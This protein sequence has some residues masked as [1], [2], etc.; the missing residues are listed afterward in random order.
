MFD[1]VII[2]AGISGLACAHYLKTTSTLNTLVLE[3]N[4]TIGGRIQTCYD[5]NTPIELGAEFIHGDFAS[6]HKLVRQAN[7]KIVP[8]PRI[9]NLWWSNG[10]S[11]AQP[12]V[13][14]STPQAIKIARLL[15][16]YKSLLERKQT[17]EKDQSLKDYL[18]LN[19]KE[20]EQIADVLF[21]QTCCTTLDKLSVNDIIL[22][23]NVSTAGD[24][25]SRIAEGYGALLKWISKDL[26]IKLNTKVKSIDWN[27][28][29]VKI[30]TDEKKIECKQCVITV[31]VS[32]LQKGEILF[33]PPLPKWKK[34]AIWAF[35]FELGTKLIYQFRKYYWDTKLS[36]MA[37]PGICCRW[38]TPDYSRSTSS[39]TIISY[40]TSERAKVI[41]QLTEQ[42]ALDLGLKEL[43]LLLG[44]TF[45]DLK[46]DLV[47]SMRVSWAKNTFVLGAYASLKIG[48]AENTRKQLAAPIGSLLF[49]AGEATAYHSNP[50]TVN[51]ALDTGVRAAKEILITQ[52]TNNTA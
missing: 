9:G 12:V 45:Q 31:P 17:F 52:K 48:S 44:Y 6:T 3:A 7:L 50:Q 29:H 30:Q 26:N 16:Q 21:A 49:F 15:K 46:K 51:G 43:S 41:D 47:K 27:G 11:K 33:S 24:G 32:I 13:D 40:I 14:Q 35:Q 4:S 8:V 20:E 18:Q 38:W 1:V 25:E 23:N 22:E 39:P 34:D 42:E 5:F 10:S 28:N 19:D 37:H 36:Y 2:G